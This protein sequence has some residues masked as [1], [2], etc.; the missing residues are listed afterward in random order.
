MSEL[1]ASVLVLPLSGFLSASDHRMRST[2][3]AIAKRLAGTAGFGG[4]TMIRAAWCSAPTGGSSARHWPIW[5]LH[6]RT[7]LLQLR[8]TSRT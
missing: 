7:A 5:F 2:I 3:K 1:G 4:G 8:A 6:Q